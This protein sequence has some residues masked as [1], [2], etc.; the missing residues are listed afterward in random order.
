MTPELYEARWAMMK[1][2]R[3]IRDVRVLYSAGMR[4][5]SSARLVWSLIAL[6]APIVAY[7]VAGGTVRAI[8]AAMVAA[9]G[10]A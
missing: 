4:A 6:V 2:D 3:L 9:V 10:G 1:T 8:A 5:E 7:L